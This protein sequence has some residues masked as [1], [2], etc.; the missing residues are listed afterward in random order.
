VTDNE[1]NSRRYRPADPP[2]WPGDESGYEHYHRQLFTLA[3]GSSGFTRWKVLSTGINIARQLA[4]ARNAAR[5][6]W[7][8]QHGLEPAGWPLQ[9]PPAVLWIPEV[10]Y[11][12][13]LR[14]WWLG[15]SAT[16][17]GE[18]AGAARR[19]AT[20]VLAVDAPLL[21]L[22]QPVGVWSHPALRAEAATDAR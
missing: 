20:S 3:A 6:D 12:A 2:W 7:T 8:A 13:C 9:H 21:L 17:R 14:C 16:G 11:P 1:L 22:L 10:A 4:G 19:H 15:G 5:T 18:A